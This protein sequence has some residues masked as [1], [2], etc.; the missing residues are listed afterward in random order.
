MTAI[1]WP[2]HPASGNGAIASLFRINHLERA[3]SE[4][5]R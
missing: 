5:V 3:V 1:R 2:N 4:P